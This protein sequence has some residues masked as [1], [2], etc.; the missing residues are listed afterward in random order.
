MQL[1]SFEL[2]AEKTWYEINILVDVYCDIFIAK[3]Q[4]KKTKV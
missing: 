3:K 4:Q 2:F 1:T